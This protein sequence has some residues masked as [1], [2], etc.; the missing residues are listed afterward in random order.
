MDVRMPI[1]NGL[2][3]G[4]QIREMSKSIRIIA[5]SASIL[6]EEQQKALINGFTDF[7]PKPITPHLLITI[8]QAHLPE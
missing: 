2:E 7:I 6:V 5:V 4:K 1:M 3:A 8:M